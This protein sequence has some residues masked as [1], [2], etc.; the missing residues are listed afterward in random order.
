MTMT[1][2]NLLMLSA[3]AGH[4]L[5]TRIANTLSAKFRLSQLQHIKL[6]WFFHYIFHAPALACFLIGF[7]GILSIQLQL[8][9][10]APLEA[11]YNQQV[12]QTVADF[13]NTIARSVND[14]MYSQSAAYASDVNGRVD[15]I[16]TSINDGVFG[17]VNGTTTTLNTTLN[18]FYSDIENAVSTVFNGT[19]LEQP[20]RDFLFCILG[21][22][23]EAVENALTFLHDNLVINMPRVN[24][25]VLVLSQ[26]DVDEATRPI[27][28]AAVGGGEDN[29]DGL[30]GRL[31]S[32]YVDA[33][34]KERIMFAVFLFLWLF[35]VFIALCILFYQSY[36]K[37]ARGAYTRRKH[38]KEGVNGLAIS[39]PL[40]SNQT[41]FSADVKGTGENASSDGGLKSYI[42]SIPW[43][44]TFFSRQRD[45]PTDVSREPGP[46]VGRSWDSFID[47]S[48]K[49]K[50]SAPPITTYS[51]V[52]SS[53]SKRMTNKLTAIGRKAM[54]R[55]L[56]VDD[57][58]RVQA[59]GSE[60]ERA[61]GASSYEEE[62]PGWLKRLTFALRG[63]N[64]PDTGFAVNSTGS[65]PDFTSADGLPRNNKPKLTIQ[66]NADYSQMRR[67]QLPTA[68]IDLP[69]IPPSPCAQPG[70][71][72]PS[73]LSGRAPTG[74][75][76]WSPSPTA[77]TTHN[78]PRLPTT[79]QLHSA[80]KVA[81]PALKQK[82]RR[83]VS[84]PGVVDSTYGNSSVQQSAAS[85]ITDSPRTQFRFQLRNQLQTQMPRPP[86]ASV[87][88]V[89]YPRTHD[90]LLPENPLSPGSV[91]SR[92]QN[93]EHRRTSSIPLLSQMR[94]QARV[95]Q[96]APGISGER[97]RRQSRSSYGMDPFRTPFD[98]DA[99]V[100]TRVEPANP[101]ADTMTM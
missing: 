78:I 35:V 66:T 95:S 8:L 47:T 79:L 10:I 69:M 71:S 81:S 61:Q 74:I 12:N 59:S 60:R 27:S 36:I 17:W 32:R 51:N 46:V 87:T 18:N 6:Q 20:M 98:D 67:D 89:R 97:H 9:A 75:P 52:S 64:G 54:G 100:K 25:S 19:I 90:S 45:K 96:N 85:N 24:D 58:T 31:I 63:Q 49:G 41:T 56:F 91:T 72:S 23:V 3:N 1:D 101:F 39:N 86:A 29:S 88:P 93:W 76:A 15:T 7:F 53:S 62:R 34:K 92:N 43:P 44:S 28:L 83:N 13:S 42:P 70:S 22:K 65:I 80:A 77:A 37:P 4:P 48:E 40:P 11:K 21:T 57:Q 5:L 55:E 50:T 30:V 94:M 68:S 26:A 73:S 16:Q 82:P 2:H 33:L 14:S 38:R 99:A 84:V